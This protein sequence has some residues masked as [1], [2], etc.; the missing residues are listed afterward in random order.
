MSVF[1]SPHFDNHE[2]VV[3]CCDAESGLKA[4]IAIH[5]T[6][7]GPS[8]GGCRMWAYDNEADALAD[9]MRLSR[10][11]TYKSAVA[12][13]PLGGGKSVIIGD[14]NADKS[15]QLFEAMGRFVDSLSGRYIVAED[16]G[17]DVEDIDI[18]RSQTPYAAGTSTGAGNPSPST[19]RGVFVGIQ[20]AVQF[21]FGRSTFGEL[22]A[23]VQGL[24]HVGYEVARHLAEAG[25]QLFV[26]DI[27]KDAIASA[28]RELK[29]TAVGI[30]EI[31]GLDVDLFVPCALGAIVNDDT[32]RQLKCQVVAGAANNQLAAER[33]GQALADLGIL[34][35]PDY[36]INAGG[37]IHV[38]SEG[39]V[40][41]A[42]DVPRLI[43]GI[44]DTLTEIFVR[45]EA[46]GRP[47]NIIADRLAEE[48]FARV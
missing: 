11:M 38:A 5:N 7:R 14:S 40:I 8:L 41:D 17:I 6:N 28:E 22:K 13:L 15:K 4:I 18:V 42:A 43:D 23:A 47:T 19:A 36:V 37:V 33:H 45:A 9:V 20:A 31:Y 30:D 10:G 32:I 21:K 46:E 12:N 3:F 24:G 27:D 35:A 44:H 2:Q 48:R 26:T 25:A 29:A 34:Y 39:P 1:E 16:V